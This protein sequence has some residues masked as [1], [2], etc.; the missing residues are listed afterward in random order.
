MTTYTLA[1]VAAHNTRKDLW[2]IIDGK[3][4]DITK[5]LDDHPG[6][7]EVLVELA[8]MDGS[9]AF[10]E[11]GH[12]DDARDLLKNML[13]GEVDPAELKSKKPVV[14][15]TKAAVAANKPSSGSWLSWAFGSN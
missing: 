12:S 11:I 10:E 15:P 9:E 1:Q 7:E 4:Y 6:G 5:F 13:V 3:V 14:P 2:M 8:G